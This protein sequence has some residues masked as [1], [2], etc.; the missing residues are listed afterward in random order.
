ME[1]V[2]LR[3]RSGVKSEIFLQSPLVPAGLV[4]IWWEGRNGKARASLS[5][6]LQML[7][8]FYP[9]AANL[10]KPFFTC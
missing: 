8:D 10:E 1:R 9:G 3:F 6:L 4:G 2:V 5:L 7:F